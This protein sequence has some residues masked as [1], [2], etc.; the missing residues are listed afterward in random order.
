MAGHS[1]AQKVKIKK[2]IAYVDG[3]PYLK[4]VREKPG[5]GS[6]YSLDGE[7]EF[8]FLKFYDPTPDNNQNNDSYWIVRLIDTGQEV[9]FSQATKAQIVRAIYNSKIISDDKLIPEK[10]QKFVN[11]YGAD[12]NRNRD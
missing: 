8:V 5:Q 11:K 1:D 10:V 7:N 2:G 6:F 12:S 4:F 3:K 9:E